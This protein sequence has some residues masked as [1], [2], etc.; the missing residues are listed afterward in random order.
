MYTKKRA[1]FVGQIYG[2]LV[3]RH[4]SFQRESVAVARDGKQ[5]FW[6]LHYMQAPVRVYAKVEFVFCHISQ[7]ISAHTVRCERVS[8][9]LSRHYGANVGSNFHT[10]TEISIFAMTFE[11]CAAKSSMLHF[12]SLL[13]R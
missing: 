8:S 1:V 7:T 11:A 9:I 4:A 13:P 2:Y 5:R 10:V 3:G 6:K 12:S